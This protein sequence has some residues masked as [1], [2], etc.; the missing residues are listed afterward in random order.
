MMTKSKRLKPVS[1]IA[2]ARERDAAR[3][4]GE[5]QGVLDQHQNKLVELIKYRAEYAEKM[6]AAGGN[7]ISAGKMQDYNSFIRRLDEAIVFQRS[8]IEL[9]VRQLE[10]KQREWRVMHTR[11]EAL[12]KVVSRYQTAEIREQD[13]REQNESDERAQRTVSPFKNL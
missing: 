12:N 3:Y 13:K 5:Q 11:S 6:V 7:G 9:A 10:V 4:M 8:Q 2:D 1:E